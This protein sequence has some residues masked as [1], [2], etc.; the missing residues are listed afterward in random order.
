M[1]ENEQCIPDHFC[2]MHFLSFQTCKL[3]CPVLNYPR[4]K[5]ILL[6]HNKKKELSYFIKDTPKAFFLILNN[7]EFFSIVIV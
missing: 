2:P 5:C 1:I 4:R 3:F 7:F 6:K